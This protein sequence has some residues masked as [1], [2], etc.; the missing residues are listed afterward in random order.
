MVNSVKLLPLAFISQIKLTFGL[1]PHET[2][3]NQKPRKPKTFTAKALK[4]YKDI[5]NHQK[6][7]YI[8]ILPI[9]THIN[10]QQN[11]NLASGI[12]AECFVNRDTEHSE[13]NRKVVKI[14][15]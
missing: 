8:T 4:I 9:Q 5:V 10:H 11:L 7:P 1:S 6:S 2:G 15:S 14:T 12:H 3:F 13:T